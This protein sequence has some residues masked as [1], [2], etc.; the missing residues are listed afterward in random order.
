MLADVKALL[1]GLPGS[2]KIPGRLFV[3]WPPGVQYMSE[4]LLLLQSK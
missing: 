4:D 3:V 1:S 2:I